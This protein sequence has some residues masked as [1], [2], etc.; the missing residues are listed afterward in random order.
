MSSYHPSQQNTLTGRLT[1]D[2]LRQVFLR[3]RDAAGRV[4][5]TGCQPPTRLE[6]HSCRGAVFRRT[7]FPVGSGGKNLPAISLERT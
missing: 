5:G 6:A 1:E 2:M 4:T 3:V 7:G